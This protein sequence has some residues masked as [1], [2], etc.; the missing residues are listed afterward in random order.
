M[1]ILL[2]STALLAAAVSAVAASAHGAGAG[3]LR[4]CGLASLGS[5]T[6]NLKMRG[7]ACA[8][9]RR[10]LTTY[11]EGWQAAAGGFLLLRF[12]SAGVGGHP[13][14]ARGN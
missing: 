12:S 10:L 6:Y 8:T 2:V 1:R 4:S 9:A 5:N 7:V 3:S 11:G 14:T 13:P